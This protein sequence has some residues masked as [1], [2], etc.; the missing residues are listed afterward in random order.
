MSPDIGAR[1]RA[2]LRQRMSEFPTDRGTSERRPST[3]R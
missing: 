3:P 1:L 2:E